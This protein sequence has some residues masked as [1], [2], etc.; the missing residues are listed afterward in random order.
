LI[1]GSNP[2][3]VKL[4]LGR[5]WG[6]TLLSF[7]LYGFY[8]VY[9]NRKL[10]D[11]E[12]SEGND[13]AVFHTLGQL[14]P[15]LNIVIAY[16]IWR[17]INRLRAGVRLEQFPV[18]LYLVASLFGLAPIFYSLVVN[19]LNEFWDV[20]TAGLATDSPVTTA[21]KGLVAAGAVFLALWFLIIVIAIVA[22]I[23]AGSSN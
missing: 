5:V 9:F 23:V 11:A 19:R 6:F 18:P 4:P 20:R 17:D 10:I 15:V 7:G 8:W 1:Q 16:W 12:L 13:D 14:V 2:Y 22:A 21:E 3:A